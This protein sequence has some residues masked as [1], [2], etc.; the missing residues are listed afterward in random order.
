MTLLKKQLALYSIYSEAGSA[1]N[2]AL[3]F[4]HNHEHFYEGGASLTPPTWQHKDTKRSH[5]LTTS[6]A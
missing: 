6:R 4:I 3:T 2:A 1:L 5:N